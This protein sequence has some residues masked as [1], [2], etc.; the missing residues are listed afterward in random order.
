MLLKWKR[1]SSEDKH[2]KEKTAGVIGLKKERKEKRNRKPEMKDS[3]T[4]ESEEGTRP[5]RK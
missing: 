5:G 4:R 2:R 3:K 1:K